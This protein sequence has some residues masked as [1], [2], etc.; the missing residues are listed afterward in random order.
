M[1]TATLTKIYYK[2]PDAYENVYRN[3]YDAPFTFHLGINIKQYHRPLAFPAFL[4]YTK[5]YALY[6]EKIYSA[7]ER[8]LYLVNSVPPVI[9]NQFTLLSILNEVKST[10]DIEGVHS[11]RKEIRDILDG[12]VTRSNRLESIVNKY[13]SLMDNVEIPFDSC[14]DVRNFYDDF[15][16]NEIAKENPEHALD[17]KIFRKDPVDI[18]SGTGKII[19]RGIYPEEKIIKTMESALQLLHSSDFP[20]LVRLG[21]FHYFFAYIHPFYDGNGRTDRFITSYFLKK[22]FHKLLG[23]RL[24]VYIKRNKAKYYQ[25]FAEADS[26][27]NR[28]DLTPF[29]IGFLQIV[30]GTIEDTI[31]LLK[32]KHDQLKKYKKKIDA[33]ELSDVLLNHIYFI[34]LQASFFY[35]RGITISELV[36]ITGKARNTV[37]KR[38]D[39]IPR[40]HLS[41]EKKGKTYYYKLNLI[42]FK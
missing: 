16:H 26:E 13:A 27:I 14:Q 1:E 34:L 39:S 29:I 3:R 41:I 35:G 4:Y 37:Q 32:R 19:H 31:S 40:N 38:I 23:L 7:Y 15:T 8:F 30:L 12:N 33:F 28:G 6:T 10:N 20:L 17:G 24:S 9:L 22:G 5:E 42:V 2:S 25:L 36:K 18:E 11:T 21:L